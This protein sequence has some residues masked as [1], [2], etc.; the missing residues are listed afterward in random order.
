MAKK[1]GKA[2]M[3]K[4]AFHKELGQEVEIVSPGHFP[5]TVVVKTFKGDLMETDRDNLE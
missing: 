5:T 1:D 4:T 3:P 2:K